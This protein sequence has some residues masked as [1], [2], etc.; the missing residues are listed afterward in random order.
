MKV[1][2]AG[3]TGFIGS[4]ILRD[5]LCDKSLEIYALQRPTSTFDLVED[6]KDQVQWLTA[7][8]RDLPE[9]SDAIESMDA[10][11]NSTGI[12][13][14]QPALLDQ[15][16][17]DGVANLVNLCL[18]HKVKKFVHI[19]SVA[20]MGAP[21]K[22]PISEE[23]YWPSK[24]LKF[25]Y[26]QSKY[27][28]EQHVWRAAAEGM[29]I[30]ILNP[31]LVLGAGRWN[32]FPS[33]MPQIFGGISRY[34][35]GSTGFV[36]VRDVAKMSIQLLK[37]DSHNNQRFICSADNIELSHLIKKIAVRLNVNAPEKPLDGLT[38][39]LAQIYLRVKSWI[40]TSLQHPQFVS[41]AQL[42]FEYDNRKSC[43]LLDFKYRLID[44]TIDD[45]CSV[46]LETYPKGIMSST[47]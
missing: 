24:S 39:I 23:D 4:Y 30:A 26:G 40:G 44:D 25:N 32:E 6:I 37:D 45:V 3:A 19:S 22:Q 8:I 12:V 35:T 7:D 34:P 10:V 46:F 18:H 15:I 36:D 33:L 2:L 21:R 11:I 31:S 29:N 27:L 5:L 38:Y 13:T 42:P 17:I 16:N 41:Y 47:Y 43:E 28:G 14:H 20:A 9:L 1:L